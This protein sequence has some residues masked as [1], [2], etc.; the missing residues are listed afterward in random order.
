MLFFQIT[1]EKYF[2]VAA[3]E[4]I[5]IVATE[6][7]KRTA[8]PTPGTST[9]STSTSPTTTTATPSTTKTSPTHE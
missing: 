5:N 6:K 7:A 9:S 1:E 2:R 4:V 8:T 3:G